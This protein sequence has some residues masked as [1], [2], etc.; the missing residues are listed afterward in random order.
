MDAAQGTSADHETPMRFV[1]YG[2]G[3]IGGAI[4]GRL[5]AGRPRRRPDRTRRSHFEA[6]ARPRAAAGR[7][8]RRGDAAGSR[9]RRIRR[10]I[11]LE[12][13]RR[14]HPRDEDAGHRATRCDALAGPRRP[15]SPSSARRT[16]STNERMALRR[17][18]G[19]YAMCVMLPATHLEPG[20][21]VGVVGADHRVCS[22]SVAIRRASTTAPSRSPPRSSARR[23]SRCRAP[24]SC[25]GS[26]RSC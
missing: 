17:F 2:A 10:A 1:V 15:T 4:G 22:T 11:D 18:A 20:V 21:V 16:A 3:A 19:V 14:R 12:A 8:R 5:F 6:I 25:G 24:T 13:R 9:R 26:T 7:P 23:S